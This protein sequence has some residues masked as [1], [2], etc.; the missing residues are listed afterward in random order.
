M[1]Y[2]VVDM[3]WKQPYNNKVTAGDNISLSGEIVQIGAVKLD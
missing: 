3:E 1:N 2:I